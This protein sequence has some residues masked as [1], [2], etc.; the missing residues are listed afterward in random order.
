[1]IDA[2]TLESRSASYKMEHWLAHG[3]FS[4]SGKTGRD[5]RAASLAGEG[6]HRKCTGPFSD[7]G[8][9]LFKSI[10]LR[11]SSRRA[12]RAGFCG[13][14]PSFGGRLF[15]SI[16]GGVGG[17]AS[18]AGSSWPKTCLGHRLSGA[19]VGNAGFAKT[20][21]DPAQVS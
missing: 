15:D 18:R 16:F 10:T 7:T 5:E 3:Y 12:I 4:F 20:N 1:M 14:D 13:F 6:S 17:Q 8:N 19:R 11:E 21:T 9:S 2:R